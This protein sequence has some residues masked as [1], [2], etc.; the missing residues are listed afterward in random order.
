MRD[1]CV[2]QRAKLF[3]PDVDILSESLQRVHRNGEKVTQNL[4][5]GKKYDISL[6]NESI[7]I[8]TT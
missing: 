4:K 7:E 1:R 2:N 6:K 3:R 8:K 5:S